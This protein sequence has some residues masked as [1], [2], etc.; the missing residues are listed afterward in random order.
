MNNKKA[1]FNYEILEKI[2]AGIVLSGAEV[3]SLRSGR[4][5]LKEAFAGIKNQ[6]MSIVQ[7]ELYDIDL[8]ITFD[9]STIFK[10][11]AMG[12]YTF[13]M[14]DERIFKFSIRS[15][16]HMNLLSWKQG[17]CLDYSSIRNVMMQSSTAI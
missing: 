2:E 11:L 8:K 1:K 13:V 12:R 7:K 6:N 3:K 15:I 5:T 4:G 17:L 16:L 10:T 9:S 14:D